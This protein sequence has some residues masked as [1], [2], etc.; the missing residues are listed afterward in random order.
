MTMTKHAY[1]LQAVMVD[2]KRHFIASYG[3]IETALRKS[4]AHLREEFGEI[5]EIH[6]TGQDNLP[7]YF[8]QPGNKANTVA[9]ISR[10]AAVPPNRDLAIAVLIEQDVAYWGEEERETSVRLNS[11]KTYG[12]A[13]NTLCCR[14]QLHE[15]EPWL[16]GFT[17]AKALKLATEKALTD[18]DIAFL[19]KGG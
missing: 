1:K 4:L 14:A 9:E 11:K 19:R 15:G 7:F 5:C 18:S 3:D 10:Y 13:L 16:L 12:L 17:D 8:T 6:S 2:G